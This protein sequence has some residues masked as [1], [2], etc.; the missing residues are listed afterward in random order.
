MWNEAHL[1]V[2]VD[3]ND[4]QVEGAGETPWDS[5]SISVAIENGGRFREHRVEEGRVI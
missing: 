2:G 4:T 3:V 5:D 1:Y